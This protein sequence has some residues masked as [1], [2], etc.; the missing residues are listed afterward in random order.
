MDSKN[1]LTL[2]MGI[3]YLVVILSFGLIIINE[4]AGDYKKPKIEEKLKEYLK[5]NYKES[6]N[7]SKIKY[8]VGKY[9][10]K[11]S[12][13]DNNH[14][15]FYIYYENK[16]ITNTYKKDYLEGRTLNNYMSKYQNKKIKNNKYKV[17]YEV[18]LN[19][20]TKNVKESLIKGNYD[21]P[22]YTLYFNDE[23]ND[24]STKLNEVKNYAS[25]IK[26]NPKE[27]NLTL[28]N[29]KNINKSININ[30]PSDIM[31]ISTEILVN[32]INNND[33]STLEK[34]NVKIKYLN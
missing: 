7:T 20:C 8:Q 12:N 22:I 9:T 27:Y 16:K 10:L 17:K 21:L 13:K 5:T 33:K 2:G 1:K 26:L 31:N 24:L 18:K 32:A 3:L 30:I 28:E 6:F 25:S 29:K 14:L 19:N 11:V 15:Y 34:F 4:K 23:Y